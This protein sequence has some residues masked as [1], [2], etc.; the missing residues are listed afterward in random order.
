MDEITEF[1]TGTR[2]AVEPHRVLVT[3]LF[4]DVVGSTE[5]A[6]LVGDRRWR[7]LLDRHD[8]T[9]RRQLERFQGREI[10]TIGDGF[11]AT[12]DNPVGAIRCVCAIRDALRPLGLDVRAG[13]HTGMVERRDDH[14]GGIAVHVAQRVSAVAD[15]GEVLV[16]RTVVDLVAGSTVQFSSGE[17]HD[18]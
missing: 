13:L 6:A 8:E 4:T 1:I 17:D 10:K 15:R 7:D 2:P 11:L 9:V 3:L 5:Q 16:S 18:L 12:F 14:I